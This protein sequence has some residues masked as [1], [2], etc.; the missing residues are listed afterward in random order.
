MS[1]APSG[2][3]VAERGDRPSFDVKTI[4]LA[5]SGTY[6]TGKT[7]TTEALSVLT[8]IPRIHAM[9]A[10]QILVDLVPG[11]QVVDLSAVELMMLGMRRLEER[12]HHEAVAIGRN[13][14][15]VCDGSVIHE[16]V[17]GEARMRIGVN[18]A[19]TFAQKAVKGIAGLPIK[20]F[21]QQYMNAYGGLVKNRAQR[22]YDAYIHLPVEFDLEKDGHRPVSEKFRRLSDALL[23][24]TL[25]EIQIPYYVVGGTVRERLEKIVDIFGLPVVMPLDDAI[26]I[27]T[28]RV[29]ADREAIEADDRHHANRRA[30]SRWQRFKYAMRY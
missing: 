16:W 5:V 13:G 11:K 29:R 6:S 15:F 4:H 2:K 23:I 28:K 8:G 19:G 20:P 10:R 1:P 27:A 24:E 9:T 12:I 30:A 14:P 21:Y 3:A 7:T 18:P 25:E 17:Y 22:I 26:E